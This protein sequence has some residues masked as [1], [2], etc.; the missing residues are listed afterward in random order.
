MTDDEIVMVLRCAADVCVM[1]NE[2]EWFWPIHAAL[3]SV[4]GCID[5]D[6]AAVYRRCADIGVRSPC[7][8]GLPEDR[9]DAL[10]EA[11][12]RIEEGR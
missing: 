11:A 8:Y 10:L 12:M 5:H 7:G 4:P 9:R 6:L 3:G 2:G 1:E